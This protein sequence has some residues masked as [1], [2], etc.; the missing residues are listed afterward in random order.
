[1]DLADDPVRI[2]VR[3]DREARHGGAGERLLDGKAG[4]RTGGKGK[5]TET[6]ELHI[7]VAERRISGVEEET[8]PGGGRGS[9]HQGPAVVLGP[10]GDRPGGVSAAEEQMTD[11]L[12]G[13]AFHAE[14][15]KLKVVEG[16]PEWRG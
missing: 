13:G 3:V 6:G 11:D 16:R 9:G 7:Q 4:Y 12:F 14:V 5:L 10:P 8:S 15:G 2:G 1:V